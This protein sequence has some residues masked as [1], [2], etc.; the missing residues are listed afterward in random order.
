MTLSTKKSTEIS[1]KIN[2]KNINKLLL[3]KVLPILV[4]IT[5]FIIIVGLSLFYIEG[6]WSLS[7]LSLASSLTIIG[8]I[9]FICLLFVYQKLSID[10]ENSANITQYKN[11]TRWKR[12]T[13]IFSI[14]VSS[15]AFIGVS[16][17]IANSLNFRWD[18]TQGKQHT[19]SKN[20]IDFISTLTKKVELTALY[21]GPP[22]KYLQD[23]FNEYERV[24][25]GLITTQIIDPIENIAYAAKFGNVLNGKERK[26]IVQS[27]LNSGNSSS[28]NRQDIDFT[29]AP[30]TQEQ[31]THTIARASRAPRQAYFLNGHGEYSLSNPNNVGLTTFKQLLADNNIESKSLMLGITQVIPDDCDVLIIAGPRTKLTKD[32]EALIVNYLTLGGDA[33]FL[34]E[35]TQVTTPDRPL[36]VAQQKQNPSLNSI[37]N[38]WGLNV[39]SDIVVDLTNHIGDDV[40]S[41][42]TKNYQKHKAITQGLDYTFYVRP[43]SIRVL[44]QRRPTIK[45]AAIA[46]TTS[47]DKSWAE[48]NRTLE[49]QFDQGLDTLGPV[50][51]SYVV[52]EEHPEKNHTKNNKTQNNNL[53]NNG[54]QKNNK[55][56]R[57]NTRI[58]VFTDADFLTNVYINQYSNAQMGV[59]IVNWLAE[60]D[61]QVVL[62]SNEIKVERLHLTSKQKRQVVVVLFLLPFFFAI[63]GIVIWL[64]SKVHS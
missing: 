37:I 28:S 8:T 47:T 58:I 43:R 20:T 39:Q 6:Q 44:E 60:L 49:I 36:T 31:L 35:H 25:S 10:R 4:G 64:R 23:L 53:Q 24:S 40:G 15:M 1:T 21:V 33:L 61:Y 46:S 62:N 3:N 41:P 19:L 17:Y 52:L 26:V 57:S 27:D 13:I 5:L 38:Q 11:I 14:V 59:N 56:N 29:D 9:T 7:T 51:F 32:E 30:L 54:A 16:I 12:V 22:P 50:P 34:I 45:L 42:A 63:A 48:T 2:N 18:V 55:N